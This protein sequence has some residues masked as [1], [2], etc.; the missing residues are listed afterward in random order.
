M[1]LIRL[2][3]SV[4][5]LVTAFATTSWRPAGRDGRLASAANC[6]SADEAELLDRINTWRAMESLPILTASAT[7][8][9]AAR[10]HAASMAEHN[11]FPDDYSVQFEGDSGDETITWQENIANAGYPDNTHTIRG[12]IIGAGTE[13]PSEIFALLSQLP[14]YEKVLADH[15]FQ[16]IG[17]GF[18][19]N[20]DSDEGSYWALTFASLVDSAIEPCAGVAVQIAVQSGGRSLNSSNS[21][22]AFDGD[23]TTSWSTTGEDIPRS[24]SIWF[25]L[26][27]SHDVTTIEW[28]FAKGG[29]ADQF[30]IDISL[31]G[32]TWETI[33]LKGN[34]SVRDW[35]SL[36]VDRSAR[37]IRFYFT[38]PNGDAVLGHLAEV[39]IF[40]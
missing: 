30:S 23:L 24:A 11:Y 10:N 28:M 36:K 21:N 20:P 33:A 34:G 27:T 5:I 12:S 32:E 16:A 40:Q 2:A 7:L 6:L 22:A 26:G 13:S 18:A 25:D 8:S 17:L 37:F 9:D 31:D 38:N 15:R 1:R 3:L 4:M 19:S 29:A 39:R 35:R 14:A